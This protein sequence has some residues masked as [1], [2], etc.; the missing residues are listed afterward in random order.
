MIAGLGL[1]LPVQAQIK[2]TRDVETF[3]SRY[4][5]T[6]DAV[7]IYYRIDQ[8]S[9]YKIYDFSTQNVYVHF[10]DDQEDSIAVHSFSSLGEG[11]VA[12]IKQI[13]CNGVDLAQ[14]FQ[15]FCK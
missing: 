4:V 11:E 15:R 14:G 7:F 12:H 6:D 8:A 2:T 1:V 9:P 10:Q 13:G 5:V 3:D